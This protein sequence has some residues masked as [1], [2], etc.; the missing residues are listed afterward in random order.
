MSNV[1]VANDHEWTSVMSQ[2]SEAFVKEAIG[3]L[4]LEP[5]KK[6]WG[7]ESDDHFSGNVVVGGKRRTA[8]FLLKGP[9]N[10]REM[11]LEMMGKRA[12]QIVRLARTGADVYVVQHSHLIGSAVR[13]TLRALTIM[14]GRSS[15]KYCLIDGLATYKILRAYDRIRKQT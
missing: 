12:D 11:T 13:E 7:G 5:T 14:P 9:T 4:L 10:F 2:L 1:V 6:D 8:A 3:S 15:T